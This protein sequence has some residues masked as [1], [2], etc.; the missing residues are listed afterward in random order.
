MIEK[1]NPMEGEG[2][3]YSC[4]IQPFTML[5]VNYNT[6]INLEPELDVRAHLPGSH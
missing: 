5:F 3:L 6:L 1:R 4:P 2:S